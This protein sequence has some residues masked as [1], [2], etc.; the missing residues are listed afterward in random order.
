M[1]LIEYDVLNRRYSLSL[2]RNRSLAE[3]FRHVNN[4]TAKS[5]VILFDMLLSAND[6]IS[7]STDLERLIHSYFLIVRK[8]IQDT[9][10]KAVM[11]FLV[12]FVKDELQSELVSLLYKTS[13]HQHDELLSESVHIAQRRKDAGEMLEVNRF[14]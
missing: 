5:S 14:V 4:A 10:P 2:S 8:N 3:N 9:V 6:E 11:H 12:N 13:T 1:N 7:I